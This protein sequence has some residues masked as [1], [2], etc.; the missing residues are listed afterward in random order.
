LAELSD[1]IIEK[2]KSYTREKIKSLVGYEYLQKACQ[3]IAL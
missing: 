3:T 1:L 2:L